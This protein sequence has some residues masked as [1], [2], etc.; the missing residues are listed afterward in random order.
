MNMFWA[1]VCVCVFLFLFYILL[2]VLKEEKKANNLST[3]GCVFE[4]RRET[5]TIPSLV[6]ESE[7]VLFCCSYVGARP[8]EY[9]RIVSVMLVFWRIPECASKHDV[10]SF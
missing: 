5:S 9:L 3:W 6:C 4:T 2:T 1:C 10:H 8:V 7:G